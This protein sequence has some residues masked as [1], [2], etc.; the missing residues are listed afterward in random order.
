[1]ALVTCR[2]FP[3]L[4]DDDQPLVGALAAHG[5]EALPVLWDDAAVAWDA[6]PLVVLRNPWD[7]HRRAAEFAAWIDRVA[8]VSSLVNA[9]ALLEWNAHKGYLR[10]L[11]ARGIRSAPTVWVAKGSH[12]DL[13]A[14]LD[15]NGWI[16]AVVK[17]A[18]SAGAENTVR[19]RGARRSEA[20][21]LLATLAQRGEVLVQ[22]YLPSVE[23]YGERSLLFFED[24]SGAPS[25]SHAIRKHALL[26]P[27]AVD[28]HAQGERVP[29]VEPSPAELAFAGRVLAEATRATGCVPAYARVDLARDEGGDPLLMELEVLE[30]S[31]FLRVGG[32]YARFASTLARRA[33]AL[34]RAGASP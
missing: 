11:E 4:H 29:R 28:R 21:A 33:F 26:A 13:D 10:D 14:I 18:V 34:A 1:M 25:F 2:D 30:P 5:I 27:G 9:R 31:L 20:R 32:A 8:R 3:A 16:D 23:S 7:Y 17:P 15:G 12:V 24:A 6:F 19:V 22:P